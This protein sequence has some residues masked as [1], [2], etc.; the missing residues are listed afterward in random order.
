MGKCTLSG[1]GTQS[2]PQ[3]CPCPYLI[4]Q[5]HAVWRDLLSPAVAVGEVGL[6][7]GKQAVVWELDPAPKGIAEQPS[8]QTHPCP[9]TTLQW[10]QCCWGLVHILHPAGYT[11]P[12][13][14]NPQNPISVL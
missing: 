6:S 14:R 8:P 12:V 11:A 13:P 1:Q 2:S 10:R 9:S 4:H 3:P 5:L 7:G